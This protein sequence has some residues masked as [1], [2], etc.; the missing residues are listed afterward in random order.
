MIITTH[1]IKL[2]E[3]NNLMLHI[4]QIRFLRVR[5]RVCVTAERQMPYSC[6]HTHTHNINASSCIYT[7]IGDLSH[8]PCLFN[9]FDINGML[10]SCAIGCRFVNN[11]P[12]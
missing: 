5:V 4:Q 8:C 2:I 9:H 12:L 10:I 7:N 1:T 11:S 6:L 3:I